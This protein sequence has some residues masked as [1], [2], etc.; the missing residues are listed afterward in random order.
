MIPGGGNLKIYLGKSE[1]EL[2]VLYVLVFPYIYSYYLTV[3]NGFSLTALSSVKFT[4][5]SG[6]FYWGGKS[7]DLPR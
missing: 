2:L 1:N 7:S 6:S 5:S 3:S 4:Q